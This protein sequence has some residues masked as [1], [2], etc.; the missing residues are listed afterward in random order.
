MSDKRRK[1]NYWGF[2]CANKSL[3]SFL[4]LTD[5]GYNS[6]VHRSCGSRSLLWIW[7]PLG[8]QIFRHSRFSHCHWCHHLHHCLLRML[9]KC[10][11]ISK[12]I[13]HLSIN[14]YWDVDKI[15]DKSGKVL[16]SSYLEKT[17]ASNWLTD[18]RVNSLGLF[19]NDN[20]IEIY[21]IL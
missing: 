14:W 17:D 12:S 11:S 16:M 6:P 5:H 1:N 21:R 15:C 7:T 8:G 20:Y 19:R 18:K 3:V 2:L 10:F 9:C 4:L 13:I